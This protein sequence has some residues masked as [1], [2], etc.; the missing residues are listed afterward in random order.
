[1]ILHSIFDLI[2]FDSSKGF[3]LRHIA[4]GPDV[5]IIPVCI[6]HMM[7]LFFRAATKAHSYRRAVFHNFQILE[8]IGGMDQYTEA[9]MSLFVKFSRS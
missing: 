4:D 1:M 5:C 8:I 2:C 7:K 6:H 9:F 3:Y